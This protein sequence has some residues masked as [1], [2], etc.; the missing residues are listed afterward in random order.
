MKQYD[1]I[2]FDLDGTLIDSGRGIMNGVIYAMNK[3]HMEI[4]EETILRKFVGPPIPDAF[5]EIYGFSRE[6]GMKILKIY[7]EYYGEKVIF[8]CHV[9]E[10]M[11]ERLGQFKKAGK[12]L[13]VATLKPQ[14][15]AECIL[16]KLDL[17]H[18]FTG[19]AGAP[20]NNPQYS[21]KNL[22]YDAMRQ[23]NALDESKILMIGDRKYDTLAA[24]AVGIDSAGV[25]YGYGSE[26]EL[27]SSKATYLIK[28]VQ[29][30][31]CFL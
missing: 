7:R 31:A 20:L 30:L 19:I 16:K 24:N 12:K 1:V 2:L 23:C 29:T 22:I 11:Q 26:E 14:P 21:K 28:D 5:K 9:Y 3:L 6:E 15:Y 8:E 4:P 27:K 13:A 18:Y 25:L 10:G 17:D